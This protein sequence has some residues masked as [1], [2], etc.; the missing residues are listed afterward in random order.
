MSKSLKSLLLN[1]LVD[2]RRLRPVHRRAP[3]D[4]VTGSNDDRL[5]SLTAQARSVPKIPFDFL[6]K[7]ILARRTPRW[8]VGRTR[9]RGFAAPAG[10]P[11]RAGFARRPARRAGASRLALARE[12]PCSLWRRRGDIR[13]GQPRRDVPPRL[14]VWP[15]LPA[16]MAKSNHRR[17]CGEYRS[18]SPREVRRLSK[19]D[20]KI[21]IFRL[22]LIR[23]F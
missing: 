8:P 19:Y 18:Y 3:H 22:V 5:R 10:A 12:A 6:E 16:S 23:H 21:L 11:L 2:F 15:V 13:T 7:R 9:S 1:S 14:R 17:I 4:S 20:K